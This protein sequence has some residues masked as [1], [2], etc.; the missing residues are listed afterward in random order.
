[1]IFSL[2]FVG[3]V[4]GFSGQQPCEAGRYGELAPD[5]LPAPEV[6]YGWDDDCDA[7]VG[8]SSP[9]KVDMLFLVDA[10]GSMAQHM[11]A[12]TSTINSYVDSVERTEHRFAL[13]VFPG[14]YPSHPAEGPPSENPTLVRRDFAA[15]RNF[16]RLAPDYVGGGAEREA[17]QAMDGP[18]YDL[19]WRKDASHYIIL[20]T[21]GELGPVTTPSFGA[22]KWQTFVVRTDIEASHSASIR[23]AD[24]IE[25]PRDLIAVLALLIILIGGIGAFGTPLIRTA[26][27]NRL[28]LQEKRLELRIAEAN[29]QAALYK[30]IDYELSGQKLKDDFK[31]LEAYGNPPDETS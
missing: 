27:A 20:I 28:Q 10:S 24:N 6:C 5:P 14:L 23:P 22:A 8:D 21:D 31:A 17:L 12:L 29:E 15:A 13:I 30:E 1:M 19:S 26:M 3:T 2:L 25:P 9:D 11:A 16:L 7:T 4:A 18:E